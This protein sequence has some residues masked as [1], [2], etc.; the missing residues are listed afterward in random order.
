MGLMDK[1]KTQATAL[2]EKAQEGAK[3]GQERLAQLQTKRQADAL[4]LEF[5]GIA[6]QQRAGRADPGAEGRLAE[7]TTQIAAYEALNGPIRV[8]RATPA[9]GASGAYIPGGAGPAGSAESD[10]S[11]EP[12]GS[13]GPS[14]PPGSEGSASPAGA[15]GIPTGTYAADRDDPA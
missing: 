12:E 4:L 3:I 2:A 15:G 11:P 8:T 13:A 5:G 6:Y 1:M 9:P 14:T 10:G 7:L